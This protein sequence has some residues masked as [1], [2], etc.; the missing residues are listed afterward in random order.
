MVE[1]RLSRSLLGSHNEKIRGDREIEELHSFARRQIDRYE[2][3][4]S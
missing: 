3:G 1:S 2:W 4:E